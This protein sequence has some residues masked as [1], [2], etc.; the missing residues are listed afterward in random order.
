MGIGLPAVSR[1]DNGR[2]AITY[3]VPGL[4]PEV[5]VRLYATERRYVPRRLRL[6]VPAL[7][8]VVAQ[9]QAAEAPPW[10]PIPSR[11]F[12][13]AL[14][15][16]ANHG[17]QA[18][19]TAVR[20]RVVRPDGSVARWARVSAV[21]ADHGYPVGWAHGDDR[22]EF[23][24]VLLSSDAELAAPGSA[25]ARVT[26]RISARPVRTVIDSPAESEADPLWDLEIE[27]L[28]VPRLA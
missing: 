5:T 19:A 21:D 3:S 10:P 17:A 6:P 22:G 14:Y 4:T 23:L 15:P 27:P 7:A 20:G 2:F 16:G 26:L 8:T 24:L 18:G 13:P 12:R 25:L 28:P 9:E 1:N 11:V